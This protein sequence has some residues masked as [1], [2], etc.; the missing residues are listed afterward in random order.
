[1]RHPFRTLIA[2][3]LAAASTLA[4]AP[5][6]KPPTTPDKP[7]P[8][9]A[10]T[11]KA[12]P[13]KAAQEKLSEWPLLKETD[14]ERVKALAG[15]FRKPDEKLHVD[16][17]R[18]LVQYG[19]AAAPVLLLLVADRDESINGK[20]FGVL[21]EV[22]DKSHAALMAREAKKPRPELRRYLLLRLCRFGDAD[23]VPL[24]EATIADKDEQTA[25]YAG[26]G[27]LASK[28]NTA[29]PPVLA[30]CKKHWV[31]VAPLVA[32]VLPPARSPECGAFVF[33]AIAKSD[34]AD[35]MTGLRLLRYLMV[36]EQGVILRTYLE[37][38]DHAV[39]REAVNAA[40]VLNGEPPIDNLSVFQAIE[41]A[42]TWLT[43]I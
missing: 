25:F 39:K 19:A 42:K 10:S 38:S 2:V 20:L 9:K 35:Q 18:S 24:F 28:R 3:L 17:K 4:M 27:L 41:H 16:A 31:E 43:K 12:S 34:V 7:A 29:L 22:L 1:M 26:L 33:E 6:Q 23:L 21:D 36:K 13:E 14:K 30:Y 11:E 5:Q 37:A 8:E 40:R 32:E 15:Q